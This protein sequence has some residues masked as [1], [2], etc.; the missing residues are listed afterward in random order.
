MKPLSRH[1]QECST[2]HLV[3]RFSQLFL[4]LVLHARAGGFQ[5]IE[6]V[7]GERVSVT[8]DAPSPR[9]AS[10]RKAFPPSVER[11]EPPV[12]VITIDVSKRVLHRRPGSDDEQAE[13]GPTRLHWSAT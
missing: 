6:I 5:E 7:E 8:Y 9:K 13:T 2:C 4:G 11:I 1:V 10:G 3:R 12:E